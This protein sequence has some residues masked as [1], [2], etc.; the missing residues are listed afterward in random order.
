[1]RRLETWLKDHPELLPI[2]I[3]RWGLKLDKRKAD[4]PAAIARLMADPSRAESVYAS[5]EDKQ[6]D[7][8]RTLHGSRDKLP[9]TMFSAMY[10]DIR[11]M[12]PGM[13][14]RDKPHEKP[15]GI[16]E[17]LYYAGFIALGTEQLTSGLGQIVYIPDDLVEVLPFQKTS[18]ENLDP[19]DEEEFD[20]EEED[21][22]DG[23]VPAASSPMRTEAKPA[24][25]HP[26]SADAPISA[27]PPAP[28][29]VPESPV[30][31]PQRLSKIENA[32][33]ADTSL[34]DDLTTILA[35][36]Q[37]LSASVSDDLRLDETTRRVIS[38]H[39][40]VKDGAR[41]DFMLLLGLSAGL[42]EI[43]GG[44]VYT[45][46]AESR[47]WL[48]ANRAAQIQM[49]AET[50]RTSDLYIDLVHVPGLTVEQEG[51]SYD[52]KDAR[53]ALL[54]LIHDIAPLDGAWS[55]EE[56]IDVVYNSAPEF[57]RTDFESWYVRGESG[58][59]VSGF[60]SWH[61]V[62]G[63]LIE[64][65]LLQPMYW[66]GLLTKGDA[67]IQF[68]AYGRAFISRQAFPSRPDPDD[69]PTLDPDGTLR[70]G[71]SYSR[72]DRFQ[73]ARFTSWVAPAS[74]TDP[75]IY[76]LD[77]KG[78]ERGAQQGINT[79]QIGTYIQRLIGDEQIPAFVANLLHQ[80]RGGAQATVVLENLIVLRT[81]SEETLDAIYKDPNLRRYLGARLGKLD[82]VVRPDQWEALNDAL[83][84]SGV[85]VEVK[86]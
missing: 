79:D 81:N 57:Q 13:I 37:V 1:M 21:A 11:K 49:L 6:R 68:N 71:R 44:K 34:V 59:Y 43:Q 15:T 20:E 61:A 24:A 85:G 39:L 72:F 17:A 3:K 46:R 14:E 60:E 80:W 62:E 86:L 8:L 10:K 70:I 7:A 56:F 33:P 9:A 47:R 25:S 42:I 38:A 67:S 76:R 58:D 28:A 54:D 26:A 75:Y 78:I 69:P 31:R 27:K 36:F 2:I 4:D 48:E 63:A 35:F 50:W 53:S 55:V 66:L 18:Y 83:G 73:V 19:V 51:W 40:I 82:V 65:V 23:G 84:E 74:A 77:A 41:L 32:R 22:E 16:A 30:Q 64:F 52:V 45:K 29:P 5:L 12:G